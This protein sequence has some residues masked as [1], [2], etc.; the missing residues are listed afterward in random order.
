[1]EGSKYNDHWPLSKMDAVG[2]CEMFVPVNI[3]D[4]H[5]NLGTWISITNITNISNKYLLFIICVSRCETEWSE[6][7]LTELTQKIT[8]QKD[9][10]HFE[11]VL[12]GLRIWNKTKEEVF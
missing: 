3:L 11:I 4:I 8:T 9:I 2:D 7:P 10:V 12:K 5:L 6:W 1:M